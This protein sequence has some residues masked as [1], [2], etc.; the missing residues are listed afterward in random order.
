MNMIM[1]RQKYKQFKLW[2]VQQTGDMM[3]KTTQFLSFGSLVLEE[4]GRQGSSI[5]YLMSTWQTL[6]KQ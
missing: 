2:V 5:Y 6:Q 1:Y 4:S 3:L